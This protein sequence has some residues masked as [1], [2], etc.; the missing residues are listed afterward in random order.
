MQISK[1]QTQVVKSNVLKILRHKKNQTKLKNSK[2]KKNKSLKIF[3]SK[4]ET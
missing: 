3:K 4:Y 1:I 2:K